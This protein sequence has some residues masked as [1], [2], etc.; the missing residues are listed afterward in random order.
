[1]AMATLK[2][3]EEKA[4]IMLDW[5]K[6]YIEALIEALKPHGNVLEI[7]FDT[8]IAADLIQKHRPK[9]HTIIVTDPALLSNAKKWAESHPNTKIIE[10]NNQLIALKNLG[11]FDTV[12]FNNLEDESKVINFHNFSAH[13]I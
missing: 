12:Y 7:G 13:I 6:K 11:Q 9:S 3:N 4:K 8:G 1:M 10:G 2:S 5:K